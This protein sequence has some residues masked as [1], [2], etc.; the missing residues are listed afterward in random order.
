MTQV[1]D[2]RTPSSDQPHQTEPLMAFESHVGSGVAPSNTATTGSPGFYGT[3]NH[4]GKSG[5]ASDRWPSLLNIRQ[6]IT[7][8]ILEIV[9]TSKPLREKLNIVAIQAWHQYLS[10]AQT[11]P[12]LTMFI[13]AL[14]LLSAGP[15]IVFACV[16]GVSLGILVGTAAVFVLVVQSIVVC[17][18]G[19]IL[20]FIL[21][22]IVVLTVFT[23]FWLVVGYKGFN[24]LR[25]L[26]LVLHAQ[27]QLHQQQQPQNTSASRQPVK[28]S[29]TAFP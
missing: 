11:Y 5:T 19:A 26:G 14:V 2:P 1:V 27:H 17:I 28:T 24:F 4:S 10:Y 21:G 16:T 3:G 20:L 8:F 22:T 23:F 6:V 29:D 12:L 9:S 7:A 18:A 15:V 13:S 25:N